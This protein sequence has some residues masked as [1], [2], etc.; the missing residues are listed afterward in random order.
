LT[1]G[2]EEARQVDERGEQRSVPGGP[3]V[4]SS[5]EQSRRPPP[6]GNR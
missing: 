2:R 3:S 4:T 5:A 6:G 1:V